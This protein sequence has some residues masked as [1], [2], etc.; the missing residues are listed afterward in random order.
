MADAPKSPNQVVLVLKQLK[1]LWDK[2]PKGRRTLAVLIVVGIL[3]VVGAS[4]VLKKT[5]TWVVAV[6]SLAPDQTQDFYTRLLT[7]GIDARMRDGKVEVQENDLMLARAIGTV[8]F[9]IHGWEIMDGSAMGQTEMQQKLNFVRAIQGE[10]TRSIIETYQV[11]SAR[12][13]ITFGN[14]T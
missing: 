2:Q 1:E 13:S 9:G 12:V 6:E 14:Q 7:R 5:E 3:A 10:L 8:G 11:T 4:S